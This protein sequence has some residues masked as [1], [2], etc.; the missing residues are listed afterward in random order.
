MPGKYVRCSSAFL[1]KGYC[2]KNREGCCFSNFAGGGGNPYYIYGNEFGRGNEAV[3]VRAY[4]KAY[5]EIDEE[6]DY[7]FFPTGTGM[8]QAGL[9]AGKRERA[10]KEKIIGISVARGK[11]QQTDTVQKYLTAYYASQG[12]PVDV[13][14]EITVID[15]YIGEGY[16]SYDGEIAAT[17]EKMYVGCGIPLDMTYTGKAFYGMLSYIKKEGIA[18]KKILFIHTGGTPLFFDD[19]GNIRRHNY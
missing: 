3:P 17:I 1:H 15:D 8:T 7:I 19:I 13:Q 9:I 5:A 11:E 6:Y 16:G 2:F 4:A 14:D 18:G 10:R 12:M